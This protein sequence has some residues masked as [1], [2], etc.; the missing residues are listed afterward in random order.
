MKTVT[1]TW[2]LLHVALPSVLL[3]SPTFVKA[4]DVVTAPK[5]V[6][7]PHSSGIF[8]HF[9]ADGQ[10]LLTGGLRAV[11]WNTTN[12]TVVRTYGNDEWEITSG[13]ISKDGSLIATGTHSNTDTV[14]V[15]NTSN[16]NL[17][18]TYSSDGWGVTDIS[19]SP[20]GGTLLIAEHIWERSIASLVDVRTGEIQRT[21]REPHIWSA[22]FNHD[23]TRIMTGGESSVHLWDVQ[24]GIVI[25]SFEATG[26]TVWQSAISPDWKTLAMVS[27]EGSAASLS[28]R[29]IQ[30]GEVRM[31]EASEYGGPIHSIHFSPDGS[32]LCVGTGAL[33]NGAVEDPHKVQVALLYDVAGAKLMRVFDPHAPRSHIYPRVDA[34]AFSP[35]GKEAVTLAGVASLWDLRD[36]LAN[37]RIT[38]GNGSPEIHWNLGTLQL[39]PSVRGPWTDLPAA[40]PLRL[41]TIGE[42]GFF[43]VKV[44]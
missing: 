24:S 8:A 32:L 38:T 42:K 18:H 31:V 33:D 34:V 12:G 36:L 43:R 5:R 44:E 41:S 39:A 28:F 10:M 15:W 17:L 6:F 21:F 4:A 37:P 13:A 40:S 14:K 23:G 7:G 26:G 30:T 20:D 29:A 27:G 22:E 25:A 2:L 19:F 11:L 16:G 1:R 9:S 3:L 35:D